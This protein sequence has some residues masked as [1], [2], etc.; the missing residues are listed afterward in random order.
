MASSVKHKDGAIAYHLKHNAR[1]Y[2]PDHPPRN[3]DIRPELKELNYTLYPTP[4]MIQEYKTNHAKQLAKHTIDRSESMLS[5]SLYHNRMEEIYRMNRKDLVCSVQWCCTLPKELKTAPLHEQRRF[6]EETYRFLNH[7]YGAN[8]CIHCSVHYDEGVRNKHGELLIG[9][10]HLHYIFIP[11][12]PVTDTNPKHA[13]S[14][15]AEKLNAKILVNKK[16]LKSFHSEYQKWIH[17]A[18]I[19]ANVNPKN[20]NGKSRSVFEL[21]AETRIRE[22]ELENQQLKTRVVKLEHELAHTKEL[23]K[24]PESPWGS[25]SG[26]GSQNTSREKG[27][28]RIWEKEF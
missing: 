8:N 16:H 18:G 12:V 5:K 7:K 27:V 9:S 11:T 25:V 19:E 23:S 15:F 14:A 20:T 10:P 13:Q 4:D 3:K 2:S 21:K 24:E 1:E 22:L 17:Q 26:W 6:F 28:H